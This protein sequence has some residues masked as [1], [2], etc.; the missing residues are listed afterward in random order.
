M[1][2]TSGNN[3]VLNIVELQNTITNA[4]GVDQATA[5]SQL[6]EM[7]N[8]GNKSIAV[9]TISKFDT[10]PIQV[11]DPVNF[12]S[13]SVDGTN[14]AGTA[15]SNGLVGLTTTNTASPSIGA[16]TMTVPSGPA[17]TVYGDGHTVFTNTVSATAFITTSDARMKKN[18]LPLESSLE[19]INKLQ[20]VSFD[21]R[22]GRGDIGFLAQDV[23]QVVP[24][25]V[26]YDCNRDLYQ[27]QMT[28][29]IPHLV[30]AVKVL[31]ARVLALES[32]AAV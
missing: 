25:A 2:V 14:I 28:S 12:T 19:K 11:T 32:S 13:V 15:I 6:Q 5:I 18:I 27:I 3:F 8:Y 29:I 21:W 20:G 9:N 26:V 10:S 1:A 16:L 23:Q 31:T 24:E 7:V 22:D 17:M 30:E 4:S